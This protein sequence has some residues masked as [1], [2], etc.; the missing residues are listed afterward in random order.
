MEDI[1]KQIASPKLIRDQIQSSLSGES[2]NYEHRSLA[3]LQDSSILVDELR[4]E[5][6]DQNVNQ[7]DIPAATRDNHELLSDLYVDQVGDK[8][9]LTDMYRYYLVFLFLG[10]FLKNLL[11]VR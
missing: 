9:G 1:K 8:D 3:Q 7:M 5:S 6:L 11:Y 4:I 2:S 10:H